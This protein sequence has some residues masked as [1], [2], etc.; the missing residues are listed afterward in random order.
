MDV[1]SL[2]SGSSAFCK[3]SLNIWKFSV[4]I[5]LMPCL[6]NFEPYF[7]SMWN[8]CNCAL[9]SSFFGI[10][11]LWEWNENWPFPVLGHYWGLQISWHTVC[12]TWA[13]S[14]F[15]TWN[16]ST[17]ILSPPL[18]LFIVILPMAHLTSDSRMSVSSWVITRSWLYWSLWSFL[19]ISPC[20]LV[21]F[22]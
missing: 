10:V 22:S 20:I 21:A 6:E 16:S 7:C 18:A 19:Y 12:S 11:F 14:S 17:G 8:E 9:V 15:R 13:T 4:H 1:G 3:S 2:I 5:L